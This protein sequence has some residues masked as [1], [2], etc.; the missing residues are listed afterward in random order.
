[1]DEKGLKERFEEALEAAGFVIDWDRLKEVV[2][3]IERHLPLLGLW[4]RT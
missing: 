4:R 1:M 2:E 3:E